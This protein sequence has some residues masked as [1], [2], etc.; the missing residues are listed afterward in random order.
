MYCLYKQL[1]A[2]Q[3]RSDLRADPLH[4]FVHCRSTLRPLNINRMQ[5]ASSA[6]FSQPVVL[7]LAMT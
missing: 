2:E 1:L 5:F 6:S 3:T 7:T 4:T